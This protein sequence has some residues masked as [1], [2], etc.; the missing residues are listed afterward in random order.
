MFVGKALNP[1]AFIKRGEIQDY[2]TDELNEIYGV[3]K[4]F[5]SGFGLPYSQNWGDYPDRFIDII[6]LMVNA[7]QEATK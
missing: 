4:R 6:E 3:W 1:V 2:L 5:N 7:W